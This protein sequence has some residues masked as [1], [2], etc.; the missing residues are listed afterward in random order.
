MSSILAA[1]P[2]CDRPPPA[3]PALRSAFAAPRKPESI[4]LSITAAVRQALD[5]APILVFYRYLWRERRKLLWLSVTSN[6][7]LPLLFETLGPWWLSRRKIATKLRERRNKIQHGLVQNLPV[8]AGLL[9][10]YCLLSSLSAFLQ[11]LDSS[12]RN[13]AALANRLAIKRLVFH[14]ILHSNSAAFSRVRTNEL[15]LRL[16]SDINSS[17]QLVNYTLPALAGLLYTML[18]DSAELLAERSAHIDALAVLRPAVVGLLARLAGWC[19]YR[20]FDVKQLASARGNAEALSRLVARGQAAQL[21]ILDRLAEEELEALHGPA[22]AL[23]RLGAALGA[24]NLADLVSEVAVAGAVMRRR[25]VSHEQYQR[26]QI[27]VDHLLQLARHA[28]ALAQSA[29]R[30]LANQGRLRDLMRAAGFFGAGEALPPPGAAPAPPPVAFDRIVVRGAR[31]AYEAPAA[32]REGEGEGE[33][34]PAGGDEPPREVALDL[35][36][37]EV[38]LERGR[39]YALVGRNRS[40]KSTLCALLSGLYAPAA[41]SLHFE[42]GPPGA[43]EGR[44]GF[45]EAGREGVRG[46]VVYVSQRPYLFPGTVRDNILVGDPAAT[47]E[48]GAP[49][50]PPA[51]AR[52]RP[53]STLR[54][55]AERRGEQRGGAE[56][57]VERGGPAS[58]RGAAA[59]A[60]ERGARGDGAAAGAGGGAARGRAPGGAGV[61]PEDDMLSEEEEEADAVSELTRPGRALDAAVSAL[62]DRIPPRPPTWPLAARPASPPG[63]PPSPAPPPPRGSRASSPY[64]AP[65]PSPPSPPRPAPPARVAPSPLPPPPRRSRSCPAFPPEPGPEEAAAGEA[66]EY[67]PPTPLRPAGA[68]PGPARRSRRTFLRALALRREGERPHPAAHPSPTAPAPP[69]ARPA[70]RDPSPLPPTPRRR[71]RRTGRGGGRACCGGRRRRW[72]RSSTTRGSGRGGPGA[73]AGAAGRPAAAP[74]PR[75]A[76]RPVAARGANISGG[77]AQSI[78]LARAY[79]RK[80]AG[81]LILDEAFSQMDPAKRARVVMPALLRHA[82]ERRLALLL[83]SHDIP[84]VRHADAIFVLRGGRLAGAGRH[85][86]LVAGRCEAYLELL[87]PE[88]EPE[89]A[90]EP[91]GPAPPPRP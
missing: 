65:P 76:G 72:R 39:A 83:V 62:L 49:P 56:P 91:P 61:P 19:K 26:V 78:A 20:M 33:E 80:N 73:L 15:E 55:Q 16:M 53:R 11:V 60:R 37:G 18:R 85:A 58:A 63:A 52:P 6:Y 87:A 27:D 79:L 77:F 46:A 30:V 41:G 68:A 64:P 71:R 67:R 45:G 5:D 31:F 47:H 51:P 82:R 8:D 12:L 70:P 57:R 84:S 42:R 88:P 1:A 23:S 35:G 21:S 86:E 29:R 3:S 50:A 38:V 14:R 75:R 9:S 66:Y 89:H 69:P 2:P 17:I 81:L 44:V 4:R 54:P 40:G 48:E 59:G 32:K 28:W 36:D 7:A 90:H 22:S 24:R 74:A 10:G 34:G 43:P 13:R 25:G